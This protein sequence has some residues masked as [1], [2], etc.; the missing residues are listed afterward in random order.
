ME[1][2]VAWDIETLGLDKQNDCVTVLAV[3]APG[4]GESKVW[5]FVEHNEAGEVVYKKN[6]IDLMLEV[7]E[8]F[9][10][11]DYLIGYNTLCFDIPFLQQAFQIDNETIQRWVLKSFDLHEI[12][13]RAFGRTFPLDLLLKTNGFSVSKTGTGLQAV[14]QA[15]NAEWEALESYCLK[16]AEL[17]YEISSLPSL[18]FPEGYRFRQSTGDA[19]NSKKGLYLSLQ[20]FPR[21]EF[22]YRPCKRITA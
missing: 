20:N 11:A 14:Q 12:A 18:L 16:D 4:F 5:R 13:R 9:E 6:H 15:R 17:T 19:V 1:R 7:V 2:A 21:I 8:L 22:S 3:H 10:C